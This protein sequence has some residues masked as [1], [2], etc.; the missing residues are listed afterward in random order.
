[1]LLRTFEIAI[2]LLRTRPAHVQPGPRPI[3]PIDMPPSPATQRSVPHDERRVFPRRP[4]SGSASALR[5]APPRN[6]END[7]TLELQLR[8]ISVGGVSGYAPVPVNRGERVTVFFSTESVKRPFAADG[9]VVRCDA[10]QS[11]YCVA[12][13]FDRATRT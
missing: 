6:S 2:A 13:A 3:T 12:I 4:A 5:L 10:S 8:D 1:L 7:A 9:R 11:G